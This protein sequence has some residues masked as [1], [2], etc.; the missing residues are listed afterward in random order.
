MNSRVLSTTK[1]EGSHTG[2]KFAAELRGVFKT[3]GIEGKVTTIRTDNA[4]NVKN[5]VER[6]KIRHQ[7][8]FPHTLN[9]A[10]KESIRR[11][12]DVFEAKNKVKS[13]VT[14][15]HHSSLANNALQRC[16]QDKPNRV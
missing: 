16:T 12:P 2:E 14:Y 10:V 13:I 3:W 7:A 6:L 1:V 5:A 15:F 9:L 8:C 11:T 4:A